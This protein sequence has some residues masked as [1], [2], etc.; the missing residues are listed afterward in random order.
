[1]TAA[2]T[3]G[4]GRLIAI[5]A[6]NK[7]ETN[8]DSQSVFVPR[9]MV[10]SRAPR[11]W[12]NGG[13]GWRSCPERCVMERRRDCSED[14][15]MQVYQ[16]A[17]LA[18]YAASLGQ[19]YVRSALDYV[20]RR[21]EK[22]E[23]SPSLPG[24]NYPNKPKPPCPCKSRRGLSQSFLSA[25]CD[26]SI[27]KHWVHVVPYVTRVALQAVLLHMP[28]PPATQL[29]CCGKYLLRGYRF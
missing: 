20:R 29:N 12:M 23:T 7:G 22:A 21:G 15:R 9:A 3:F 4:V 19:E 18:L 13:D 5:Q 6:L 1:M 17:R 2:V 16:A 26:S 8:A 28:Q 24:Q 14:G 11:W 27:D 25:R 10:E